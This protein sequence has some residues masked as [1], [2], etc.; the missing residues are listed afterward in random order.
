MDDNEK[1][2]IILI[3]KPSPQQLILEDN[4]N[5]PDLLSDELTHYGVKDMHWGIRRYQNEDG[6]LTP[7]GKEHLAEL[8]GT[9]P[10]KAEKFEN[11]LKK[12][13]VRMEKQKAQRIR[14]KR[15]Y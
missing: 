3:K 8:R 15:Q 4:V 13:K 11:K 5:K 12:N 1:K 2:M 9:N 6:T 10:R 14:M 7:L